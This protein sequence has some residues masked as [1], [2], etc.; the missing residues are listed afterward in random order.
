MWPQSDPVDPGEYRDKRL[1]ESAANRPFQSAFGRDAYPEMC[2]KG[3]ALFHSLIAN[4]CF[5]NGNK[6]TAVI[7]LDCFLLANGVLLVLDPKETYELARLVAS[8]R[9]RGKSH[10]EVFAEIFEAL[11]HNAVDLSDVK[12]D[13]SLRAFHRALV[14]DRRYLRSHP[15]NRR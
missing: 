3:A 15:L 7:A 6:R 10:E 2:E 13:P 5:H 9:E 4:H 12:Q 14:R 8:Y 1:I 11:G